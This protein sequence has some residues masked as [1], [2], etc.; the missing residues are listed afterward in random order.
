MSLLCSACCYVQIELFQSPVHHG[1]DRRLPEM[2]HARRRS[3]ISSDNLSEAQSVCMRT[4]G[5]PRG[6]ALSLFLPL[7]QTGQS[8]SCPEQTGSYVRHNPIE[9]LLPSM[10]HVLLAPK[11][12]NSKP[13]RRRVRGTGRLNLQVDGG[14]WGSNPEPSGW[15]SPPPPR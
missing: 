13:N 7:V 6:Q 12:Q 5:I 4:E 10:A 8:S 1:T 14:H 9:H 2:L 11:R 15:G 3:Y